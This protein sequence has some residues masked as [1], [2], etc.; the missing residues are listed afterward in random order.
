VPIIEVL[1]L[2]Q[3]EPDLAKNPQTPNCQISC[4]YA[5][6]KSYNEMMLNIVVPFGTQFRVWLY[7]RASSSSCLNYQ[8]KVSHNVIR[9]KSEE[10]MALT[11][12]PCEHLA[13]L[14]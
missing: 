2:E 3:E 13:D 10:A 6:H 4:D 8:L 12:L 5:G 11:N 7:K 1:G 9:K 14:P